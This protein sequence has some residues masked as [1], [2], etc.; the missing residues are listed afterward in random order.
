M[1]DN[2]AEVNQ[3]TYNILF[4]FGLFSL[5]QT[6]NEHPLSTSSISTS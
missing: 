6:K 1:G 3:F 5:K 2:V 4:V